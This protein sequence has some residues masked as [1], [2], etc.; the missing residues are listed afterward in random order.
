VPQAFAKKD[1]KLDVITACY[2]AHAISNKEFLA[3]V[4]S[5]EGSHVKMLLWLM[6]QDSVATKYGTGTKKTSLEMDGFEGTIAEKLNKI[7]NTPLVAAQELASQIAENHLGKYRDYFKPSD[8][9]FAFIN[10]KG[11]RK[12][13]EEWPDIY[14]DFVIE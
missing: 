9:G 13:K 3:T 4:D 10:E 12:L 11:L 7:Q 1:K 6:A 2:F 5:R 14:S 8:L